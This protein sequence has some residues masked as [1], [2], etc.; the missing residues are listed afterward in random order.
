MRP[1]FDRSCFTD[2]E[3]V[4]MVNVMP[5]QQLS[6]LSVIISNL[7]P[8]FEK[9]G[10]DFA[11]CAEEA[12]I[13]SRELTDG[14]KL[15]DV[16]FFARMLE[17][18]AVRMGDPCF[19]LRC[20]RDY[21]INAVSLLG[22]IIENAPTIHEALGAMQRYL[23]L[24]ISPVYSSSRLQNGLYYWTIGFPRDFA[25]PR[26]QLDLFIL[27]ITIRRLRYAAD[28]SW[29]LVHLDLPHDDPGCGSLGAQMLAPR[30][31]FNQPQVTVVLDEEAFNK[32]LQRGDAQLYNILTQHAENLLRQTPDPAD[33]V[34]ITRHQVKLMLSHE[35]VDL[36]TIADGLSLS[37]RSLQQ[38]LARHDTSFTAVLED[39]RDELAR[40]YL[41]ETEL[42]MIDI[43]YLLGFS[44]TSAFT[45]AAPRWL[46]MTPLAFRRASKK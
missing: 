9:Y 35:A 22:Y 1:I 42:R 3:T 27:A 12:G 31:N 44:E 29:Q 16:T 43:A 33:V 10:L 26:L 32:K 5:G 25:A 36:E 14:D 7:K 23:R 13:T 18:A 2:L 24:V 38:K 21:P 19:G 37:P 30:I 41:R 11:A 34:D 40:Y 39:V 45:R 28:P 15:I 46:G 17:T 4:R 6:L 8:V 20:A